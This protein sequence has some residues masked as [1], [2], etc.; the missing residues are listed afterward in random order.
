MGD[1]DILLRASDGVDIPFTLVD[2]GHARGTFLLLH[3][4]STDKDEYLGF[5]SAVA[6]GLAKAGYRS[7]R[8]D[9]RGHGESSVPPEEF[10]IGSQIMDVNAAVKMLHSE[11]HQPVNLFGCSFGAPPCL[12]AQTWTPE[13]IGGIS[14][15]APV[16]DYWRTFIRPESKWGQ[17]TF[18]PEA[19]LG[20]MDSGT[21]IMLN[22]RFGV[23]PRLIASM[24]HS[25][26]PSLTSRLTKPI[27]VFHGEA[28]EMVSPQ[29]SRDAAAASRAIT[30]Q[31]F[32]N[33]EHGFTDSG[34]DDGT[35]AATRENVRR[36]LHELI[37]A[38]PS[39][40]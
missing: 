38:V 12:F 34:D 19:L 10:T 30:L 1:S 15:L 29:I 11:F 6:E 9:F 28:D 16:L 31:M 3:G 5:L 25:D 2:P 8:I 4:I 21:P 20:C 39:N 26:L 24:L 37:A 18:T 14:L 7:L 23:G 33:M 22:E 40:G 32:P 27:K 36:M 35:R 17:E 13:L